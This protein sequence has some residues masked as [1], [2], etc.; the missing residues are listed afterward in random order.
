MSKTVEELDKEINALYDDIKHLSNQNKNLLKE[1][2]LLKSRMYKNFIDN[3]TLNNI[4][5][6]YETKIKDMK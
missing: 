5:S 1:N 2:K 3:D 6:D 4:V